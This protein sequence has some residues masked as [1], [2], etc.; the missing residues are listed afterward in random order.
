GNF[1]AGIEMGLRSVLV[2]PEF[3][4]RVER[5]PAGAA[6]GTVYRISDISL[7]S[8]LSFFLW[9]SIPD[10]ELLDLAIRGKLHEPAVLR[11]QVKRM[12]ADQRSQSLVNNFADQWLYLRNLES[13]TPD[14]RTFPD[15]DDNLRQA[16]RTETEMFFESIMRENRNVLDLL[17]ANYTF[18]NE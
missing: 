14:M 2:S 7:A 17:R 11:Q 16:F 10:D 4:F 18:V 3:L 1:E 9:S 5:D 15:F 12:L 13:I 6:P 8:R